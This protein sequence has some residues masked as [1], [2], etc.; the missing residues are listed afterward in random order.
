MMGAFSMFKIG[1]GKQCD[2]L[3]IQCAGMQGAGQQK[4]SLYFVMHDQHLTKCVWHGET[5]QVELEGKQYKDKEQKYSYPSL[6]TQS[7]TTDSNAEYKT[8]E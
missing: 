1:E 8:S 6:Y 3:G 7:M 5:K 2:K 4:W